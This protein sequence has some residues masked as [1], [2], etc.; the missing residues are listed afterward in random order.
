MKYSI[1]AGHE[2]TLAAAKE[3]LLAGGNA[4]DAAI[5]A[6]LMAFVA[7]PCMA[8]AGAGGFALVHQANEGIDMVDFFCQTPIQKIKEADLE[9]YPITVDFGPTTEDFYVGMG[10]MATPGAISGIFAMHQRWGTMP[11]TILAEQAIDKAKNGLALNTFQAIDLL[12]LKDIF[13]ISSRSREIFFKEDEIKKEGDKIYMPELA[14]FLDSLSKEGSDLFYKGEIARR[15]VNDGKELGGSLT[16]DDLS[17]YQTIFREPMSFRWENHEVIT[18]AYPSSGGAILAAFIKRFEQKTNHKIQRNSSE[19]FD[20]LLSVNQF[21]NAIKDNDADIQQYLKEE[22]DIHTTT[23]NKNS[24]TSGTSHFNIVD[25]NGMA[26]ALTTSIGEGCGYF[27]EGTDMQMNNMLGEGALLPN[28]FHSWIENARLRSMMTPTMVKKGND[29]CLV[30]GTGGA[31]RIPFMLAQTLINALHFGLPL[32][33]AV[34]APKLYFDGN[35]LNA[36]KGFDYK[37][38]DEFKFMEWSDPSLYFG[39]THTVKLYN[40][41]MEAIGDRRRFGVGEQG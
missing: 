23:L 20:T 1:S 18:T 41:Y 17:N 5:A 35:I 27:I 10:S 24:N 15:I 14:D 13:S 38:Q 11:M 26:V 39:G 9:F 30:T 19:H 12:L 36:E 8:S 32:E 34:H 40:D 7:E 22:F 6:Y 4:V 37:L 29:L 28:G 33:E 2:E 3:I 21:V 16:L 31:G 25:K